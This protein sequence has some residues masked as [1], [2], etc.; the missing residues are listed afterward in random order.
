MLTYSA[1]LWK[2]APFIR[3]LIPLISGIQGQDYFNI[4]ARPAFVAGL[5]F[6]FLFISFQ[7]LSPWLRFKLAWLNGSLIFSILFIFGVVLAYDQS[8]MHHKRWFGHHYRSSTIVFVNLDESPLE[9][10]QS[11]KANASLFALSA[12]DSILEVRGKIIM[13][14][15]KDPQVAKELHAGSQIVF[16][17]SMQPIQS[18][19]NPGSFDYK[20]YCMLQGITHQVYLLPDEFAVTGE[21]S[22]F[23]FS[24]WLLSS[25]KMVLNILHRYIP[26][27]K[28]EGVA[29]ALLMGYRDDLDRNLVQAY[30]NTGVVHIIAISGMHLAL[31]YGLL[32]LVIRRLLLNRKTRWIGAA[33]I[34]SA[35]WLF[36]LM[37]GGGPSVLRSAAMFSFMVTAQAISKKAFIY[38]SL[39][40]SAFF[41]LCYNPFYLWDAGFQLSY[42]A[43]LSIVI[44]YKHISQLFSF[45]SRILESIWKLNAVTISAQVL[46]TPLSVFHFH[47]LPNLFLLSNL[48]AVPVSG[49]ILYGEILLCGLSIFSGIATIIGKLVSWMLKFMNGFIETIDRIPFA[50]TGDL[51]VKMI[52]V[53]LSYLVIVAIA[54]WLIYKKK[55][56]VK[57]ALIALTGFA[58]L[59]TG[60]L[61]SI[62][63]K[64]KLI[65]YNVPKLQAID[66]ISG[67]DYRFIGDPSLGVEEF[68]SKFYLHPSRIFN[69]LQARESPP[70]IRLSPPFIFLGGKRILLVD[71]SYVSNIHSA[72]I[73]VDI[74][75]LSHNPR[76]RIGPLKQAFNVGLF[77]F[78]ASN[79]SWKIRQ[80]K[81]EC[82]SLLLRFHSVPD[83]GAYILEF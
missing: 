80:W 29:E 17:K 77:V 15:K 75:I 24:L 51:Q 4:S 18:S 43:V 35:L 54:H 7:S 50:V 64:H 34:L 73:N 19:G 82:D 62:S 33:I 56:A 58:A 5:V 49:L 83:E 1:A 31:I 55:S 63:G 78:D 60:D 12:G 40:G 66:L 37:A 46:T 6:A 81:N 42:A 16:R 65:I 38:N 68:A 53:V 71:S 21:T 79:T 10:N 25:R 22:G 76:V 70:G 57:Y 32:I 26:G 52:Q 3:L 74:I 23:S 27:A 8:I 47:Q 13:Y 36:S 44:F 61:W 30:A 48:V 14:F 59:R 69:R 11:Y 20:R 72:G 28:E 9:K 39:A 2:P 41:L 67:R 45:R